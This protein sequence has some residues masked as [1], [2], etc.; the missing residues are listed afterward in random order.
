MSLCVPSKPVLSVRVPTTAA[1]IETMF[2][3]A[4]MR[5]FKL[6]M[7]KAFKNEWLPLKVWAVNE[8]NDQAS[9]AS[10]VTIVNGAGVPPNFRTMP[11]SAAA[12]WARLISSRFL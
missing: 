10:G 11:S 4:L 3:T 7:V 9:S 6:A 5:V 1:L 2:S 12:S 8:L